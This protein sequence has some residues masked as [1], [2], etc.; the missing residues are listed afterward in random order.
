MTKRSEER[1]LRCD[2]FSQDR[3]SE[4]KCRAVKMVTTR[5]A[6]KCIDPNDGRPHDIPAGTRARYEHALV[7]GE[8]GQ[9]YICVSCMDKWMDKWIE[10]AAPMTDTD[11]EVCAEIQRR[12]G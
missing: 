1:Y 12:K 2:P 6:H 7:D 11:L 8:W 3:D 4:I 5:K 9:Y 10:K